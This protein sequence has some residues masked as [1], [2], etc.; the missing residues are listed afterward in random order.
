MHCEKMAVTDMFRQRAVIEFL[1]KERNSAGLIYERLRGLY[2]DACMGA[3]SVRRTERNKD[4]AHHP[5]CG[6]PRTAATEQRN[7][8][9]VEEIIRQDQRIRVR[10]I[11]AQLGV[12]HHAVQKMMGDFGIS[13]S[14]FPL[15]SPFYYGYRGRQ[16]G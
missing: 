5:R 14:L 2:G 11:A 7:K 10:E 16:N 9:K 6:R 13:E 1:K 12:G 15:D 3:S 8:Q 4:I